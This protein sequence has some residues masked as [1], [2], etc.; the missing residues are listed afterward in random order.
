M[1]IPSLEDLL[2]RFYGLASQMEDPNVI[3][4]PDYARVVKEH[5]QIKGQAEEY[6][7][8]K[9]LLESI[10]ETKELIQME[11]DAEMRDMARDEL[12]EMQTRQ[13]TLF[14]AI[15]ENLAVSDADAA[16]NCII[17][18]RAGTGGDEA[19]L[20][21][22]DMFKALKYWIEKRGWK[23]DVMNTSYGEM[24]GFKD[25]TFMV[26]GQD[27]FKFL[28]FESG[29]HRVQRVPAT[30][31]Q[32]R[33]HTSAI[34]IAVLP[35]AE[36]VEIDIQPADLK[37]D[38]FRASGP[39]GQSVNTTDSAVRITHIPTGVVATCQDEKS[40]IKN[41]DKALKVLRSRIYEAKKAEEAAARG[42]ARKSQI[43]SGDRSEKI[44]TYNYPQGRVTDH[45]ANVTLYNLTD[46]MSG[47]FDELISKVFAYFRDKKMEEIQNG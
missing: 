9:K 3:T 10:E 26:T 5:G 40:Q 46:L 25:V 27:A 24:G 15:I 14:N 29:T 17:E 13:E 33:I 16:K 32:G 28:Q 43:G 39:G 22:G 23:L 44:R 1:L 12:K 37:I 45:R 41:K 30:E 2:R 7:S 35:E 20:F 4:S 6:L 36:E 21:V 19:A 8:Y 47:D 38:V 11:D 42:E 18:M 31:T 34:T